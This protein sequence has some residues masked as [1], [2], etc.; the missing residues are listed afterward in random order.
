[1]ANA[2]LP[3]EVFRMRELLANDPTNGQSPTGGKSRKFSFTSLAFRSIT[4]RSIRKCI[5]MADLVYDPQDGNRHG[6]KRLLR[7][8]RATYSQR[9]ENSSTSGGKTLASRSTRSRTVKPS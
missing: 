1:M 2:Q 5:C 8:T 9:C 3:P 6:S 4:G 7:G